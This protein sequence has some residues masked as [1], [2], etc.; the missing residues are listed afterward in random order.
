MVVDEGHNIKNPDA[1]RTKAIKTINGQHKLALTGTPIQNKL[2]E[3]WSLFDF[4]MPGYLGT[5]TAFRD[6][7]R[8]QR[9][10]ELE[11]LFGTGDNRNLKD[12]IRPFVMR[13]LKENVAKDLPPKIVVDRP[14]ELTPVQVALYKEVLASTEYK[15]LLDEVDSKGVNRAKLFILAAYTKL[16][17]VCNHPYLANHQTPIRHQDSGNSI[18]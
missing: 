1:Q 6:P 13:R 8:T 4:A 10:C 15:K 14:V 5:R 9:A 7:V 17:A 11:M 16:R 18:A 3:L 2:E 12:R